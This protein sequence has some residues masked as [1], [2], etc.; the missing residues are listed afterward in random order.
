MSRSPIS[1]K[2]I[3]EILR[4]KFECHCS[5]HLIS[6]SLGVS[7]S[8]VFECLRRSKIANLTWPL[9]GDLDDEALEKLL[10]SRPRNSIPKDCD[11]IDWNKIHQELKRKAVTLMLLWQEYKQK[12]PQGISYS[13]FCDR[14][15][16]GS[17]QIDC[18]M[19]QTHKAGE[20]CF[21]D[22]AGMTIPV[23]LNCATGEMIQAQI[24][25]AC[26]GASSFTYF[27]ATM[28][29]QLPDWISSHV[30]AFEFFGGVP[31]II[32]PDNLKS[33]V[34]KSHRYE[35]DLNPTYQNMASYYGAAIMPTRSASPKDKAKA[36]NAVLQVERMLAKLRDQ[37]FYSLYELN[38]AIAPLRNA[39]NDR[40]FQKLEGSR[41]SQFIEI[42]Q[43]A[44]KPLP[45]NRYLFAKWKKVRAGI[46]YHVEIEGHYYS[47][48]FTLI[49]K[50]LEARYSE[51]IVEVFYK[52]K[53][54]A[55]HIK[56]SLK[57]R[58]T[59]L[60]Q[61]MPK[62]HQSYAQ[63]TPE[64]LIAWGEK[65]G[66]FT[67]KLIESLIARRIHPQQGF[68]SCLGLLRLS[69]IYGNDRLES[70]CQRAVHIQAYSYKSVE[71]ILKNGLDRKPIQSLSE[72]K[73]KV[74]DA[75]ENVRGKNYF[76]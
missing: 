67:S 58:H 36:E 37:T 35:P 21:V 14:Y 15:K 4:L 48:P 64:R 17:E 46:D 24:F 75:H 43:G 68:R 41:R 61:H 33:G 71:S 39:L 73:T 70:A 10:Y 57:G 62:S 34:T 32:V 16:K 6:K 42:E 59:T 12:N 28:T 23:L 19:R 66:L 2:K 56:S 5:H 29:Q 49:K 7:S 53:R 76:H 3:R 55:S 31:E 18:W 52:G 65:M 30:R 50:E 8:T 63:W 38:Q 11:E 69:K 74:P 25:V 45:A 26:L 20:K 60:N 72:P 13:R 51:K 47:V 27:E 9:P 54:V 44:L 40:P 1:M 22:Y